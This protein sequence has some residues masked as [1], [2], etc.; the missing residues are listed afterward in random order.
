MESIYQGINEFL[1][2]H[3]E[4]FMEINKVEEKGK[5]CKSESVME[6][7]YLISDEIIEFHKGK[8]DISIPLDTRKMTVFII[9]NMISIIRGNKL[10]FNDLM[11]VI[12]NKFN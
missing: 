9:T 8:N 12:T 3:M 4:V 7:L 5:Y 1:T 6:P 11:L 2:T 10:S